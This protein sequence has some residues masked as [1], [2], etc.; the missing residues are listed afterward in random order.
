[1]EIIMVVL[2][3]VLFFLVAFNVVHCYGMQE[4]SFFDDDDSRE[5]SPVTADESTKK[6]ISEIIKDA[7]KAERFIDCHDWEKQIDAFTQDERNLFLQRYDSHANL[8]SVGSYK[9]SKK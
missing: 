2:N 9:T 4:K 3:K 1:M 6:R 7:E 5:N 8:A